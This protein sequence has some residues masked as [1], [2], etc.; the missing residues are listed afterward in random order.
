MKF[1]IKHMMVASCARE[2]MVVCTINIHGDEPVD[3]SLY[4][5]GGVYMLGNSVGE[6]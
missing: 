4:V 6:T 5:M 2:V 3:P 1:L